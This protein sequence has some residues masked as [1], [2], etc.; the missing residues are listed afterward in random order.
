MLCKLILEQ[1]LC[2]IRYENEI[3]AMAEKSNLEF[4]K[5]EDVAILLT[6]L[7]QMTDKK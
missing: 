7:S 1:V 3:P 6:R 2:F 5:D 4:R